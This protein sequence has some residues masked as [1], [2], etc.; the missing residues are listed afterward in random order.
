MVSASKDKLQA[1]NVAC[2]LLLI[3]VYYGL[4]AQIVGNTKGK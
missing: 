4:A 2:T 3:R 1:R